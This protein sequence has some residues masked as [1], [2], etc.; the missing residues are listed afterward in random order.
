MKDGPV[1]NYFEGIRLEFQNGVLEVIGGK[2]YQNGVYIPVISD[3]TIMMDTGEL[4][5]YIFSDMLKSI[6][7]KK[8][9]YCTSVDNHIE[10]FKVVIAS[11]ASIINEKKINI[12][13]FEDHLQEYGV[14][15]EQMDRMVEGAFD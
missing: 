8:D 15:R 3:G 13:T 2:L 5:I 1:I 11:I 14:S 9:Y 7:D 12:T 4:N 10:P 6:A